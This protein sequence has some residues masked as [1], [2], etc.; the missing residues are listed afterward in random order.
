MGDLISRE[1]LID[2]LY[3]CEEL[4]GRKTTEAVAKTIMEQP[5]VEAVSKSYAEQIRW[6][7]DVAVG[8]LNEIGCQFGQKMDEVKK[9]LE[10]LQWIPCSERLP[11]KDEYLKNDGRFIVTDGNRVYQS[12]YDI[13]SAH[14]FRTLVLFDFG[15]RSNFEVD[16]CVIAWMPLPEPYKADM[17]TSAE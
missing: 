7:R 11:N 3:S 1:A 9:K 5:T 4:K 17:R 2:S 14:C 15:S 6:E 10:V 13:Y 8:Q 12:I 16:N